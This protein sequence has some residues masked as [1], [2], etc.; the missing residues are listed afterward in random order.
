MSINA[1]T[2]TALNMTAAW[3]KST[4]T[5]AQKDFAKNPNSTNW[6]VCLRAMFTYQQIGFAIRSSAVDREKLAFDLNA[7]PVGEWQ[8]AICRATL[9]LGIKQCIQDFA[10]I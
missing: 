9:G 1:N 7:N 5:A 4:L 6:D 8:N 3:A 10:V 2:L